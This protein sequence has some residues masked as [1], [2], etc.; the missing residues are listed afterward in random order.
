MSSAIL[1]EIADEKGIRELI[2]LIDI[3]WEES[4]EELGNRLW[5]D[6]QGDPDSLYLYGIYDNDQ[7][8]SAAWVYFE[9]NSSFASLWGGSTLPDYRG[10]GYYSALLAIR[11]KK[12]YKKGYRYLTVDASPMSKPI[13]EKQGFQCLAYTYGCQSPKK[14]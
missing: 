4:H 9:K 6:K 8:V 1:K 13:L 5:R 11:A 7:L 10:K 2:S 12:A 14:S 3:I